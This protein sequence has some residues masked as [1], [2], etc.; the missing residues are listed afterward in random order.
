V[1]KKPVAISLEQLVKFRYIKDKNGI[2]I[3]GELPEIR[4]SYIFVESA[5]P[6]TRIDMLVT[7]KF[8]ESRTIYYR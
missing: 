8:P 5:K 6:R 7:V 3:L 1:L 4:K 2:D